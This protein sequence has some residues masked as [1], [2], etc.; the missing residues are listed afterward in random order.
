[1][2]Q[3]MTL[4]SLSNRLM[5]LEFPP[6]RDYDVCLQLVNKGVIRPQL[7]KTQIQTLPLKTV[8]ELSRL[9]LQTATEHV[10]I[11]DTDGVDLVLSL[12]N[13]LEETAQYDLQAL[14]SEDLALLE[15][16]QM[17]GI[18]GY[19]FKPGHNLESLQELLGSQ[20]YRV[21]LVQA[22]PK[23]MDP[24]LIYWLSR[25][26]TVIFPWSAVLDRFDLEKAHIFPQL[27]RLSLIRR[28]ILEHLDR[29]EPLDA[30]AILT[31]VIPMVQTWMTEVFPRF[32][33]EAHFARPIQE[34]VLAEGSTEELLIPAIAKAMGQDLHYEGILV[35]S[36]GG[37]NQ[38][39]Q[40]YVDYAEHLSVPISIVMD[41]DAQSL[42]PDLAHYQRDEDHIFILE[43][44]EFE[45]IYAL[46]LIVKTINEHYRPVQTV[47]LE[48]LRRR[49]GASRVKML[50]SLWQELGMGWFD[51]VEF[52]QNMVHTLTHEALV[53]PP[54]KH[55]IQRIIETKRHG[56]KS[57]PG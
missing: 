38:M 3:E 35:V 34:L 21:D 33:Q 55:L 19:F 36:V 57:L 26:L 24:N 39:L 45:D 27:Y 29:R 23:A 13:A 9:I 48:Q 11:T 51:K 2:L 50:Q 4:Y 49:D 25:K 52:A 54:M 30:E 5:R 8:E 16:H 31:Q 18:H 42:L 1:M 56:R 14:V 41:R 20:G 44:G 43:E 6:Q 7:S 28:Y 53:S 15:T 10:G 47:T 46:P 12:L 22:A 37:K 17:R 32:S 40:Q